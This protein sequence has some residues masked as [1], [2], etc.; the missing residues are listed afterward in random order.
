MSRC[1][2]C[3]SR[4]KKDE[5]SHL[6]PSLWEKTFYAKKHFFP[7][8]ISMENWVFC[9][10]PCPSVCL[11]NKHARTLPKIQAAK[12]HAP[13]RTSSLIFWQAVEVDRWVFLLSLTFPRVFRAMIEWSGSARALLRG[14][15]QHKKDTRKKIRLRF[16][17]LVWA[18]NTIAYF[19]FVVIASFSIDRSLLLS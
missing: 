19:Y 8:H 6:T 18:R 4:K 13:T 16:F 7:E 9:F 15:K 14:Q 1:P 12:S 5:W 10:S 17:L 11:A 2:H 3:H